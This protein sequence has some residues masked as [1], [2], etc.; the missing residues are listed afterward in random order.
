MNLLKLW[1][2]DADVIIDLF[3]L[4]L[5]EKLARVHEIN[6]AST[7]INE[8]KYYI[9]DGRKIP[10]LFRTEYVSTGI[11][12]EVSAD[13]GEVAEI[14]HRLPQDKRDALH[15]GELESLAVLVGRKDLVFCSC[16]AATIKILPFLDLSE[17]GV[18]VER[19]L[20]DSG[21]T[22]SSLEYRHKETYFKQYLG[23]GKEEKLDY[24]LSAGR[25]PS[26]H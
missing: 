26:P 3:R 16:D 19:L 1:L 20:K 15:G 7:V 2:L 14:L 25:G 24:Y 13:A 11:V 18:S 12:H 9:E 22:Q 17:R 23:I 4:G 6:A 5:F 8:V 10:I 21:L